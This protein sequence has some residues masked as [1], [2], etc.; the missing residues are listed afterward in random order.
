VSLQAKKVEGRL[1]GA[2]LFCSSRRNKSRAKKK[3]T[4]TDASAALFASRRPF[5]AL[6]RSRDGHREAH[7][8]SRV[9]PPRWT[10]RAKHE[11]A[12]PLLVRT[13]RG[14]VS[15]QRVRSGSARVG[16]DPARVAG[17]A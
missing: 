12:A 16:P 11:R 8:Q 1:G 3:T 17:L 10:S 2:R 9:V 4:S 5:L 15:S 13:R 6:Q 7:R 14:R